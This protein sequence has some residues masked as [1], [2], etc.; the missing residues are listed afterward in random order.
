[1]QYD[2]LVYVGRFQPFHSGH[3]HVV[4]EA[5]KLS[6]HVIFVIGSDSR[7]R[8]TRNPYT[9]PER[10]SF[11]RA[12]LND[13]GVDHRIHFCPQ[14]D[15]T[16]NDD[17]WIAAIQSSVAATVYRHHT[18]TNGAPRIGIVGYAK[19]HSSYYLR[20]FPQWEL[21]NI[22]PYN[23]VCATELR[24]LLFTE[25]FD[26][27]ENSDITSKIYN[28]FFVNHKHKDI[29]EHV[30]SGLY[31]IA[32]EFKFLADYKKQWATVPYPVTFNTVDAVVSQSGHVLLVERGAMPGNGLLALPGGFINQSETL[33]EAAIRELKE[34]TK[35]DIPIPALV[36][37]I[38]KVKTY[39]DPHR[40]QRGR[41][42]TTVFHFKLNDNFDLPKVRGADDAKYASWTS[43]NDVALSRDMFFED[44][45]DIISDMIGI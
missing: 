19:D 14:V 5:L 13:D 20:K 6:Q 8:D 36:G 40:S 43:F 33:Q 31:D 27:L 18:Y 28:K 23:N 45:F 41:T 12:A 10:I 39:D 25:Y 2:F 29:I 35:L 17:R 26:L 30:S 42:I 21:V 22:T 11:I 24:S 15:H 16:Y 34:E 9:T 38:V 37:S 4:T 32:T 3:Y 1:M 44:H 7:A